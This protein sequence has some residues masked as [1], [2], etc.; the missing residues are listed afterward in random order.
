MKTYRRYLFVLFAILVW[1]ACAKSG[2]K[3]YP[4]QPLPFTEVKLTDTFWRPR[5][6]TNRTV[7]IPHALHKCEETGRL[8][9]FAIAGGIEEGEQQGIYPFDDTDVFK[10][11]EGASYALMLHPESALAAYLDSIIALVGAAQEKDGYLYTVR[12]NRADHLE[13]WFGGERW[14]KLDSS[15]ELYNAGH[16]FEASAAHYQATGKRNLLDIALKLADLV[17]GT[18]GPGKIRKPPGHQVIEMGLA[19]LYRVTGDERYISLAR[20]L[21]DV[22]GRPLDGRELRGEY[23]QDHRPVLEQDEAVGHAVR[24]GYMYAGMA[25][26]AALTGDRSY[27]KAID[28]LW[29]NVAG[30]KL[31][32]TGGIGAS[33]SNEGFSDNYDLPNMSAYNETCASIANIYWNYRLFLL[34][35]DAKYL[36]IME[37]TLYNAF[38]S[39][40]SLDGTR[41]FY[42]NPLESVGQ[43]ERSEWF[44]CACCPGNVTRFIASLPGYMYAV[45]KDQIFVN[46]YASNEAKIDVDGQTVHLKQETRYPWDGAVRLEVDPEKQGERFALCLRIPGWARGRPL[47]SDLYRYLN[48]EPAEVSIDVNGT[49]VPYSLEDGFAPIRRRWRSGD[50]VKLHLSMPVRRVAAHDSVKADMGK[51][52]LERGPLVFCAE[53]CDHARGHVRNLLLPDDCELSTE[54]LPDHLQGI[55]L[56]RGRAL[57]Y[58]LDEDEKTVKEEELLTMIPYYAWAHRGKGEMAVWLAREESAVQPLGLPTL[59]STSQVKASFGRHVEAVNDQLEPKSSIDYDTP[60]FYWW[61]HKGTTEWIQYDFEKPV[62]ISSVEVYWFDNSEEGECRVPASWRALFLDNGKWRPVYT[63]DTYGIRK[64]Q[65]NKVVFETIRTRSLRLEIQSQDGWA[66]GIHEWKVH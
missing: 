17:D 19:R 7:T 62:E 45:K 66:G 43:H 61:P 1:L 39:G 10:T 11:L 32:L 58:R 27:I 8:D 64:D 50:V 18:F 52:A 3:D 33:G 56:I 29:E 31:Y 53:W 30:K 4:I 46:L 35:G 6:E 28:Q 24:A 34:D 38:L 21:L 63:T 37:R 47:A 2:P 5:M 48:D 51:V 57:Y 25:D 16:L 42:P 14:E 9:N 60:F 12:T 26:V 20:F 65:Y 54:F 49:N 55:Q 44:G 22:R 41:F 13:K 40:I 36:D 59:A 15:H 23:N